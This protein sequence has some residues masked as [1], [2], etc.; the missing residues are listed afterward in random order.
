MG[1]A[2]GTW[3]AFILLIT[4]LILSIIYAIYRLLPYVLP[5]YFAPSPISLP[6]SSKLR[7]GDLRTSRL[8]S[9]SLR[10]GALPSWGNSLKPD[11]NLKFRITAWSWGG[12]AQYTKLLKS[13]DAHW[14]VKEQ[15]KNHPDGWKSIEIG[16]IP[17][18]NCPEAKERERVAREEA[19]KNIPAAREESPPRRGRFW[20]SLAA[21]LIR[22]AVPKPRT[23][24]ENGSRDISPNRYVA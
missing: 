22:T 6:T 19:K 4:A 21:G 5:Q 24:D 12:M 11:Y 17:G 9:N 2:I 18:W 7:G 10:G 23:V 13:E 14:R 16:I 8:Q 15:V 3:I 20:S 1:E